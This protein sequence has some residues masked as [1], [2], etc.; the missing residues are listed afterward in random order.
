MSPCNQT[1]SDKIKSALRWRLCKIGSP[2]ST[3]V[4][5][6]YFD[7]ILAVER[8]GDQVVRIE[9]FSLVAPSS[10]TLLPPLK[11]K[12]LFARLLNP[13]STASTQG[14]HRRQRATASQLAAKRRSEICIAAISIAFIFTKMRRAECYS[15][16]RHLAIGSME[17]ASDAFAARGGPR[18]YGGSRQRACQVALVILS[19]MQ[20]V[21]ARSPFLS[22]QQ[23]PAS[24]IGRQQDS[25]ISRETGESGHVKWRHRY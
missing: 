3:L 4:G 17:G 25:A 18:G 6:C 12:S 14:E 7:V 13:F 5:L 19:L 15:R 21:T 20:A 2:E 8:E 1:L 23:Q 10:P 16:L 11:E 9:V 24:L 22:R